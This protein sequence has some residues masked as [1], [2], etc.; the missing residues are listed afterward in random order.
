MSLVEQHEFDKNG[1]CKHCNANSGEKACVRREVPNMVAAPRR[2]V[3][4]L[5]DLDTIRR[6]QQELRIEETEALQR[7]GKI[8]D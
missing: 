4:A 8:R 2:R 7:V 1:I 6:R 5:D 3:S